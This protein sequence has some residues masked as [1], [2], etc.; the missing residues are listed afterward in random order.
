[1][2][3]TASPARIELQGTTLGYGAVPVSSGLDLTVPDGALT[4]IVGPNGCGKSTALRAM[5]RLLAP[6]GGTVL[7]DGG[8]IRQLRTKELARRLGLLPQQTTIPSGIRVAEL[9]ARGRHPHQSPLRQWSRDD[10]DA[11]AEA[12][13][14][15]GLTSLAARP[16]DQLSGGQRQRVW[17]AMVLA[18]QTQVLLLDEPTTFLDLTHQLDILQLCRRL[19]TEQARTVV[20]V[21]HDLAHACRFADHLIALKDGAL[22]AA[23]PPEQVVTAEFV[24]EVFDVDAIVVPDP[25]AGTPLVVPITGARR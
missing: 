23:G 17:I 5:A 10:E 24:R 6:H 9:I 3:T 4:M 25:V 11:V 18:Q 15:T 8:D 22:V 16:V 2:T 1:M 7:L 21:M 14:I 20:A 13:A 19:V 12:T